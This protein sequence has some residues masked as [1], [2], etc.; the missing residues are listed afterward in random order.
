MDLKQMGK[1]S[2][3]NKAQTIT[4]EEVDTL[5]TTGQMGVTSRVFPGFAPVLSFSNSP[6]ILNVFCS[7]VGLAERYVSPFHA[8]NGSSHNQLG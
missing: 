7:C 6:R 2:K 8:Q 1:G 4:D 3:P 5:Y